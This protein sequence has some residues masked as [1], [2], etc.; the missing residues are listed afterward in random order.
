VCCHAKI[1]WENKV[2]KNTLTRICSFYLVL[3][4]VFHVSGIASAIA[5]PNSSAGCALDLN[6]LSPAIDTY[7]H[8]DKDQRIIVAVVAQ[9]VRNLDTFQVEIN[10]DPNRMTF[11]AAYEEYSFD[12]PNFLTT[13]NGSTIGFKATQVNNSTINIANALIG[14]NKDEAPDGSGMIAFVGFNPIDNFPN[15]RLT[16]SNVNFIDSDGTRDEIFNLSHASVNECLAFDLDKNFRRDVRDA[17]IGLQLLSAMP[18]SNSM[19]PKCAW[20]VND[21][22][23]F[24]VSGVLQIFRQ[25]N[26][27]P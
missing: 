8:A 12:I 14:T 5:G 18:V 9:N 15:N 6:Y 16:L 13:N 2:K 20:D 23:Q 11:L 27:G 26:K 1:W 3:G 19:A 17:I 4:F 24:G 21:N 25:I 10:F 22:H 7:A